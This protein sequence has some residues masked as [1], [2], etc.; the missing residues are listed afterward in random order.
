MDEGK[1]T[2]AVA[3]LEGI[4]AHSPSPLLLDLLGDA[5]TQAHELAK[6]EKAYRRAADLDPAEL[7]HQRGLGKR[8]WRKRNTRK[9]S[10]ST[11]K[12]RI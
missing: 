9:L 3:L 8:F 10:A 6:A 12:S 4:T 5:Y 11:K 2:E 7:S 1:A